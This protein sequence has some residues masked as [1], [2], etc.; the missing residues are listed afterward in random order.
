MVCMYVRWLPVFFSFTFA[1]LTVWK[2]EA[3]LEA[4]RVGQGVTARGVK[5][6]RLS[7]GTFDLDLPGVAGT[8]VS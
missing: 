8:T 6:F 5:P 3:G 7:R 1:A 4:G 2:R